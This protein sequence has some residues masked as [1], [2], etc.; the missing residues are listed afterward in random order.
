MWA[1]SHKKVSS[2]NAPG[3]RSLGSSGEGNGGRGDMFSE[4]L[5]KMQLM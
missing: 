4:N 5:R 3:G 2:A 1:M